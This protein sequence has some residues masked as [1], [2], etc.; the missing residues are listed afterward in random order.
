MKKILL[1][2]VA[3][4]LTASTMDAQS[5]KT[6]DFRNGMS[7]AT[8]LDLN[9]DTQLWGANRTTDDGEV[10][11]W[12]NVATLGSTFMANGNPI[13]EFEGLSFGGTLSAN[14]I[15]IDA[16]T[17]R[18]GRKDNT[19]KLPKL[20]NGQTVTLIARSANSSA[21]DRGFVSGAS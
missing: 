10:Y 8:K 16:T 15:L 2:A 9:A 6:W 17:F 11:G 12:K 18:L 13:K 20:A 4:L 7:D 14:S 1:L 21:T 5:R 3:M 19:I